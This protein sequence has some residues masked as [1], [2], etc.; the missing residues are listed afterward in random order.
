MAEA[1]NITTQDD[2]LALLQTESQKFRNM[3][4]AV[5]QCAAFI[6]ILC[7][8]I[9]ITEWVKRGSLTDSST[10]TLLGLV[11]L[12]GIG[13]GISPRHAAAVRLATRY[14]DSRLIPYFIEATASHQSEVSQLAQEALTARLTRIMGPDELEP[15]V[16]AQ[17]AKTVVVTAPDRYSRAAIEVLARTAT[18]EAIEPLELFLKA[19][20]TRKQ[21]EIE[22]LK[23]KA[24]TALADIRMR[25]AKQAILATESETKSILE[26]N[27][28][29]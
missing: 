18:A 2:L 20:S 21:S 1:L 29:T 6:V 15:E 13:A 9:V 8:L 26:K 22:P 16:R 27:D 17:L 23:L 5:K 7:L 11:G 4:R 19:P 12:I 14:N 24:Q 28:L 3:D 25:V 10:S